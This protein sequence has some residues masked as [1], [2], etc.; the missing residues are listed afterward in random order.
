M[1]K[2]LAA[3]FFAAQTIAATAGTSSGKVTTLIVNAD[4]YLFFTAGIKTGS[5]ACGNNNQWAINLGTAQGK[6][7]YVMLLAAQMQ[8]KSVT[9]FGKQT[10]KEWGD[11]EDV[12][13][14]T[15]E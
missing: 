4:N 12:S 11:R 8:D 9:I 6:S 13:Y 15:M 14:G 1:Q 7:I 5:P 3:I 2:I 10:C